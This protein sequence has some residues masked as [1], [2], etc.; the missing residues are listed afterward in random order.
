[1]PAYAHNDYYNPRP[2]FD[3]LTYGYRG[4]EADLFRV[5]SELLVGHE[6]SEL[7]ASRTL[8][9]LYLEPLRQRRRACGHVVSDSIPFL[10][11]IELKEA[12]P[13]AFRLL[14]SQLLAYEELFKAPG[15]ELPPSVQVA[16]VG[17]WPRGD[18][19]PASWP[20]FVRVQ[21]QLG[22][23][24]TPPGQSFATHIAIVSLDYSKS[25]TWSGQGTPPPADEEV[26]ASA[27]RLAATYG[28]QIRVH[29]VPEDAHIY[30]WLFREGVA[31]IGAQDLP[32]NRTLLR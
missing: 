29:H 15:P 12:D 26:L 17:W 6:R 5:G 24:D 11:N 10:L 14:V 13:E 1:L 22:P 31:L 4:A 3:A 23:E 32:R 9:Q 8:I 25:L 19:D 21:Y 27:R 18:S 20:S 30:T 7:K 28:V 2:L 16:L